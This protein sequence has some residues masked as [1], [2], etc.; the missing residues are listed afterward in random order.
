MD[1]NNTNADFSYLYSYELIVVYFLTYYCYK[2]LI[3]LLY[4]QEK[5]LKLVLSF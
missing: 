4:K 5:I 3:D 1:K 2:W